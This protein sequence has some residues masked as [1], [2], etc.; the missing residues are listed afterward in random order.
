MLTCGSSEKS[1]I[2]LKGSERTGFMPFIV[3]RINTDVEL[4]NILYPLYV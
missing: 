2:R 1:L 4:N 3:S